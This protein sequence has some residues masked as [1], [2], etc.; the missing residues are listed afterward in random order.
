[1]ALIEPMIT[2]PLERGVSMHSAVKARIVRFLKYEW[3]DLWNEARDATSL[4]PPVRQFSEEQI[5]DARA[6][7]ARTDAL[8][9]CL[10]RASRTL[11]GVA[12]QG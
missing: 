3:E 12:Q 7:D 8:N 9:G 10:S 2:G 5:K 11:T 1:M 4:P 6:K